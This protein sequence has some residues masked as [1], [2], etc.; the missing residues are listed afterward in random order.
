[1]CPEDAEA[2]SRPF[3]A[4]TTSPF[5]SPERAA[6]LSLAIA[7]TVSPPLDERCSQAPDQAVELDRPAHEWPAA[8]DVLLFPSH[9]D[10]GIDATIASAATAGSTSFRFI[11]PPGANGSTAVRCGHAIDRTGNGSRSD[12]ATQG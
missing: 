9:A 3:T 5:R 8:I 11:F 2:S 6:G 7:T 1:M 4:T 10:A 12:P